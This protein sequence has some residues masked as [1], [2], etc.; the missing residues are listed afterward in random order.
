MVRFVASVIVASIRIEPRFIE[1][2]CIAAT[3]D[4]TLVRY[5]DLPPGAQP[6]V[7]A[8]DALGNLFIVSNIVEQ[9]GRR[10]IRALKTDSQGQ[11]LASLDFGGSL[12]S[13]TIVSAAVDALGNLAVAGST[14]SPDFPLVSPLMASTSLQAAFVTK[15]DSQLQGILFSTRV[16]GT[17]YLRR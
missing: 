16:G 8:A 11:I 5:L 17:D 9:S 3:P 13:D 1:R 6:R 10:Q 2:R 15:I 12:G 7:L 4:Q 14:T